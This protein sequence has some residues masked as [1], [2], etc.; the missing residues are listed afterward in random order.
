MASDGE[1]QT[2]AWPEQLNKLGVVGRDMWKT[3]TWHSSSHHLIIIFI[4]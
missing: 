3:D 4:D 2:P 1:K